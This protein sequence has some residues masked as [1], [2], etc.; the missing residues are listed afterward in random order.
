MATQMRGV[1]GKDVRLFI[2][3]FSYSNFEITPE[4][5]FE[6]PD[7]TAEEVNKRRSAIKGRMCLQPTS[8]VDGLPV[9]YDLRHKEYVMVDGFKKTREKDGRPYQLVRFVF[10]RPD[11]A[12]PSPEFVAHREVCYAGLC[13][14]LEQALWRARA[15]VNPLFAGGDVVDGESTISL[16][17]EAR[18]PIVNRNGQMVL[19]RREDD[20]GQRGGELGPVSSELQLR[21]LNGILRVAG[22]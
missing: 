22:A 2:I 13:Q 19:E 21:I 9:L 12:T 4:G 18:K 7:E 6:K 20:N 16:N 3:Q 8:E 15:F 14:L 5:L 11:G 1:V 17:F 10:A